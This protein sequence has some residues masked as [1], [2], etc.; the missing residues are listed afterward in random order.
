MQS[1]NNVSKIHTA[2]FPLD[3]LDVDDKK[4]KHARYGPFT[5]KAVLKYKD[6]RKIINRSKLCVTRDINVILWRIEYYHQASIV[7]LKIMYLDSEHVKDGA[8]TVKVL[9]SFPLRET[10]D[11]QARKRLFRAQMEMKKPT[12]YG[13]DEVPIQVFYVLEIYRDTFRRKKSDVEIHMAE[14]LSPLSGGDYL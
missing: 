4:R 10:A 14:P 8:G 2:L 12:K 3:N 7:S 11:G 13:N 1:A 9:R 5:A 6:K